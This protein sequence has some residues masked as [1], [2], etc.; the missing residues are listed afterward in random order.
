[1]YNIKKKKILQWLHVQ[2]LWFTIEQ[3]KNTK[4]EPQTFDV[5][6]EKQF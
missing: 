2:K 3:K 4:I 1:M 6:N 5:K